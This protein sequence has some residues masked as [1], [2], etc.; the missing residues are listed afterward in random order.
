MDIQLLEDIGLTKPQA[1]AYR[2]LVARSNSTAPSIAADIGESRSNTYKVL[3]K[4]CE[5]GLATKDTTGTKVQ[6]LPANPGA[7]ERLVQE[8]AAAAHSR[9]RKLNAA[10]P[11]LLSFFFSHSEQPAIRYF[12]GKTGIERIFGDMLRTGQD[13]YLLRSPADVAFYNEAFFAV[14]RKKRAKLGIT[15]YALTPNVPSAVHD[16]AADRKHNFL[17]TWLGSDE[18]TANVEWDIYGDKI[19]LISYGDEAMGLIIESKQMAESFRQVFTILKS[20]KA[21]ASGLPGQGRRRS[22]RDA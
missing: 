14:F 8:Q 3:D 22:S 21:A 9:K 11:D 10:M 7:L 12:Q 2:A 5:L 20:A 15:T 1:A 16:A 17:R 4:L 18:Y 19:A 13:I 6:Y